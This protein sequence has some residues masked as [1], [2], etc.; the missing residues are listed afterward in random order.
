MWLNFIMWYII[1]KSL[2]SLEFVHLEMCFKWIISC[3]DEFN[4]ANNELE[5]YFS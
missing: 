2:S 4:S 5:V 1:K 3:L